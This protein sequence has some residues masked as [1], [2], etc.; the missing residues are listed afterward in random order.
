MSIVTGTKINQLLASTDSSGLLFSKWLKQQGYS[1]QLQKRYRDS[2][3]LSSLSQG[4]MYRTGSTLSAFAALASCNKQTGSRMRIA[5]HSALEYAGFN[6][7]VPMGKP[8]LAV[9]LD[10]SAKRPSWMKDECFDVCFRPFHTN[11]FKVTETIEEDVK[12][13]KLY[14][15]SPEQAFF[16]CLMLAP[17]YYDYTDLYYIMEQLTTLRSDVVQLLL[18][19]TG[20]YGVKRMFLYMAEKAG[21]YWLDEL[22]PSRIELGTSK[23]Q[24]VPGGVYISKY[25]ITI[26]QSLNSYEG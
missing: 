13:G 22:N 25:K 3:W 12:G 5:A 10:T 18:E 2:G 11:V 6:H 15:S 20:N 14:I 4:V 24:L 26:P 16:E 17:K 21:H 1:D 9:C 8:V 7:Y 23:L 19:N